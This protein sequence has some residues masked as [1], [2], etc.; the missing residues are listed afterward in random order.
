M[1]QELWKNHAPPKPMSLSSLVPDVQFKVG[2][3]MKGAELGTTACKILG[4]S[5]TNQVGVMWED[6]I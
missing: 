2:V 3:A 6:D 1:L 4:L 5:N